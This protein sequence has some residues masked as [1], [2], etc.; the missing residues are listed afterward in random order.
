VFV[1]IVI[2][3]M[4]ANNEVGEQHVIGHGRRPFASHR[5]VSMSSGSARAAFRNL[6]WNRQ[7]NAA[8]VANIQDHGNWK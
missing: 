7:A 2:Q 5:T 6:S 4:G 3:S 1:D 8:V